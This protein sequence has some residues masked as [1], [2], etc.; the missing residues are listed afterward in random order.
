MVASKTRVTGY[1]RLVLSLAL[2]QKKKKKKARKSPVQMSRV[3][4][5]EAIAELMYKCRVIARDK[6]KYDNAY[7]SLADKHK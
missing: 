6:Y 2:S 5:E 1:I 7:G 3:H 4:T